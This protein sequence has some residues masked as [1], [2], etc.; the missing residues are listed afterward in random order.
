M[1][2][3]NRTEKET[4]GCD[5][6]PVPPSSASTRVSEG[7]HIRIIT[8]VHL[9]NRAMTRRTVRVGAGDPGRSLP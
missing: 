3:Q 2:K 9:H 8:A 6:P 7:L 5:P 4:R 1:V